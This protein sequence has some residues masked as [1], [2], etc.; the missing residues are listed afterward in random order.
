MPTR[1]KTGKPGKPGSQPPK[2]TK[3]TVTIDGKEYSVAEAARMTGI[4]RNA[5]YERLFSLGWTDEE[6]TVKEKRPFPPGK[7]KL[8][9]TVKTSDGSECKSA[10][11][12]A[13]E[14]GGDPDTNLARICKRVSRGWSDAQALDIV[15]PPPRS[16]KAQPK[17]PR[18][19]KKGPTHEQD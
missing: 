11:Q 16:R 8:Y 15:P 10:K 2:R 1:K 3:R 5:M 18:K 19:A 13:D 17:P 6:A 12:W 9:L 4:S 7:P 14:M